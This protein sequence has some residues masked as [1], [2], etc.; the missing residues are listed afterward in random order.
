MKEFKW[1]LIALTLAAFVYMIFLA[2][3]MSAVYDPL[4]TYQFGL[5]ENEV[6]GRLTDISKLNPNLKITFA[7]S[8]G[9]EKEGRDYHCDLDF[10][11]AKNE[12]AF[13][14]IYKRDSRADKNMRSEIELINAIDYGLKLEIHELNHEEASRLVG[15]FERELIDKLSERN[16]SR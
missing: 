7:D 1:F 10:K 3:Q 2:T 16:T 6:H 15:I 4:K 9:T 12:Y 13:H 5:T 11:V 14:F 8:I